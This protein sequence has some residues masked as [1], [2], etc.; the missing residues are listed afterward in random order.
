MTSRLSTPHAAAQRQAPPSAGSALRCVVA[1]G[2]LVGLSAAIALSQLGCTVTVAERSPATAVDGGGGLGVD[3]DLLRRATG[4]TE[5]PVLHGVDRDGTAWHLLHS[6]LEEHA[7]AIPAVTPAPGDGRG[8]RRPLG[9][10][11]ARCAGPVRAT[12]PAPGHRARDDQ[13][14]GNRRLPGPRRE[15]GGT[16]SRLAECRC[17]GR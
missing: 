12:S 6:W 10:R 14:A 17:R 11:R 13:R 5:P 9:R 15:P 4:L 8:Y 2:S 7:T 16:L 1:G 3:V